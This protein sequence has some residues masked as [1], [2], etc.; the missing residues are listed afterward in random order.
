MTSIGG[1]LHQVAHVTL[2]TGQ[3]PNSLRQE[4]GKTWAAVAVL[5]QRVHDLAHKALISW[6]TN[7]G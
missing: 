2:K 6:E 4:I 1:A 5:K 3:V 7:Y